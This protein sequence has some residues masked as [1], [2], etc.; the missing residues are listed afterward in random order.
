[1]Y[2]SSLCLVDYIG[3]HQWGKLVLNT[4]LNT[5]FL[6]H[7]WVKRVILRLF[8]LPVVQTYPTC[9]AEIILILMPPLWIELRFSHFVIM[10]RYVSFKSMLR[11][12]VYWIHR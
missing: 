7:I 6:N 4:D 3:H 8:N 9:G 12:F 2:L 5:I 1:V 10:P 11:T